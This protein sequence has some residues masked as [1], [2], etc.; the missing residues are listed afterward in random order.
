MMNLLAWR[1]QQFTISY[2]PCK[3]LEHMFKQKYFSRQNYKLLSHNLAC[4]L[5]LE[6]QQGLNV[7]AIYRAWLPSNIIYSTSSKDMRTDYLN[8]SISVT[9]LIILSKA[10]I[11]WNPTTFYFPTWMEVKIIH[12]K[13]RLQTKSPSD[14]RGKNWTVRHPSATCH[15]IQSSG[16]CWVN[17]SPIFWV[18]AFVCQ[19]ELLPFTLPPHLAQL[20]FLASRYFGCQKS[21]QGSRSHWTARGE[22]L[23]KK[24]VEP[25]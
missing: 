10:Q 7:S 6:N 18:T 12:K 23:G 24:Q 22:L 17:S 3:Y 11:I 2:C 5:T 16:V 15:R 13:V 8:S 14:G 9:S 1:T 25:V 20:L 19:T 4:T 21:S